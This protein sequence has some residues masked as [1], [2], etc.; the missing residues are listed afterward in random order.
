MSVFDFI[1]GRRRQR[2]HAPLSK[3]IHPKDQMY[4]G[5]WGHY[6]SVGRDALKKIEAVL[7]INDV[8]PTRILDFACGHGRV[9]R[10]LVSAFP[11]AEI[12]GSDVMPHAIEFVSAELGLVPHLSNTNFDD[13]KFDK[14]FDLIWSGSLMTHLN[15]ASA[16]KMINMFWRS[17]S[18]NG[19]AIWT[20]HGRYVSSLF[21]GG[22]WP[23]N[24]SHDQFSEIAHLF[25]AGKYA[26]TDYSHMK[27][28]GISMTPL[29]WL[30]QNIS[31][32]S[33]LRI[34]SFIEQGWAEHQDIVAV[35]KRPMKEQSGG[36]SA[37]PF[38][39]GL[40]ANR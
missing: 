18:P 35:V 32:Y 11:S 10:H 36:W 28:Y 12:V 2:N 15:E 17:L 4:L 34:L 20:V 25:D 26:Y 30:L 31:P 39:G 5:D 37:N 13:V 38:S 16:Q 40:V 1:A 19:V 9:A 7:S 23:Y 8:N 22:E 21:H 27:N 6:E 29:A 14:Q 33:D 24:L 3:T